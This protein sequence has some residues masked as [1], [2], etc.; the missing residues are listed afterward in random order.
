MRRSRYKFKKKKVQYVEKKPFLADKEIIFRSGG[1]AMVFNISHRLQLFTLIFLSTVFIWSGFNYYFYHN[2]EELIQYKEKELGKTRNAYIDLISDVTVLQNNLKEVVASLEEADSGL[3]EIKDYRE[4]AV[5][6]EDKIRNIADSEQWLNQ[7]KVKDKISKREALLQR[8]IMQRENDV[9]RSKVADLGNKISTLQ[10]N[11]KGLETAEIAILD[12]IEKLSGQE[13]DEI[14]KSLSKINQT[15]KVQKQYFNPLANMQEGEGGDY[16][17]LNDTKISPEL[18][19]KMSSV[20]QSIDTLDKYK[21]AMSSVP[22]GSPVYKY[23]LSSV[24]GS[25]S[26]P[27]NKKIAAHRGLDMSAAIGSRISAPA[28]GKVIKAEYSGGYGNLV[29]IEHDKG[30]VTRYAHLNK[31]YVKTGDNVAYNQAIGEVGHTGRAT[32]NH[33]HYEVLYNGRNV[34]PLTFINIGSMNKS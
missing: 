10:Q 30:F 21:E 8:E 34:N 23:R 25:R 7:R 32:G 2:S 14:K 11:V 28:A 16:I 24:F 31:M 17:P 29:E 5:T 33:L 18:L 4:Q 27:F 19:D 6:V 20:F 13:I 15:L 3:Q 12:K 1:R 26:D 22:L 9:L